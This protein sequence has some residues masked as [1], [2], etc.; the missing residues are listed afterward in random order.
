MN[1]LPAL[2]I[3]TL[4]LCLLATVPASSQISDSLKSD[5]IPADTLIHDSTTIPSQD[6]TAVDSGPA[7]FG[8]GTLGNVDTIG[9]AEEPPLPPP[10]RLI[11]S[12]MTY[13]ARHTYEFDIQRYDLY[14]R[15]AAGFLESEASYFPQTYLET[16]LRTTLASFGL[17]GDQMTVRTDLSELAPYDRTVPADGLKDFNDIATGNVGRASIIEGPLA[18]YN[19]LNGGN[20]LLYLEPFEIPSDRAT[21]RLVV[22]RGA[23]GYS[24]TRGRVARMFNKNFGFSF[25][26]DYRKSEGLAAN[27]DDDSYNIQTRIFR[28]LDRKT[29]LDAGLGVYRRA[30]G[31]LSYRRLRRDQQWTVSV[32]R[33]EL[34]GGQLTG[35]YNLDLS[36]SVDITKTIRPRDTYTGLSYLRPMSRALYRFSLRFGKEQYYINRYYSSRYYGSGEV[37][38]FMDFEAGRMFFFW[39]ARQ[40]ENQEAIYEGAAGYAHS[41]HSRWKIIIS[42]GYVGRWPDITDLYLPNHSWSTSLSESGNLE[43]RAEKKLNGNLTLSFAA[44]KFALSTSLNAGRATDLIYY[45]WRYDPY[46]KVRI[47]PEN[48]QVRFADLN[49]SGSFNDL[50]ILFGQ[51]SATVRRVNSDRYGDRLPYSPRWQIYGQLGAKH[52][53]RKYQVHLRLFGDLTY[54]EKPLSY[55][56][57]ELLTGAIVNW[58]FNATLKDFTFFYIMHN[59]LDQFQERPDG[60]TWSGWYYSWGFSWKFWD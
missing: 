3:L 27:I 60:Y 18:G 35:I 55:L 53:V 48:D 47:I 44:Q 50:W 41:L 23:Y 39:R 36:R 10:V 49:V 7:T 13:F 56:M 19:S 15:D 30:G 21:S 9:A 38:G 34:W 52:Y 14:P 8:T 43:L 54:T 40:A 57:Q 31:F 45:D 32:T 33:Q 42:G 25:S 29:T 24:Y 26:T 2:E 58:G 22:E 28:R 51:A 6:S 16:P 5:T 59:A 1:R 12:L 46:P 11:D 20:A 37:S 17:P 4:L